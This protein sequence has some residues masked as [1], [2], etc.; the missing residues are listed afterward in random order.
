MGQGK[1]INRTK[2]QV[3]IFVT[4]AFVVLGLFVGL[5]V[6]AGRGYLVRARLSKMVDAAAL[7]GAR[8]LSNFAKAVDRACDSAKVNGFPDCGQGNNNQVKVSQITKVSST[9]SDPPCVKVEATQLMDTSFIRLGALIGCTSCKNLTIAAAGMAAPPT[10]LDSVVVPDATVS[11]AGAPIDNAKAG[12]IALVNTLIP[13]SSSSAAKIS[14]VPFRGC[15]D[16]PDPCVPTSQIVPLSNDRDD[17]IN[18]IGQ[19]T[20]PAGA[21]S[22]TNICLGIRRG[23]QMLFGAGARPNAK[24]VLIILTDGDNHYSTGSGTPECLLNSSSD[25]VINALDT[26]TNNLATDFKRG[27]NVCC[28]QNDGQTVEF[29]VIR[30]VEPP[31]DDLLSGN[32]PGTCDRNLVGQGTG[33]NG[34]SNDQWDKNLSRCIASNNAMGDPDP[35]SVAPNDHYYYASTPQ[36]IQQAFAAIAKRLMR[37]LTA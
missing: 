33:R 21:G 2:G 15:F 20:T 6:D 28:G 24:K 11:M 19:I 17:L 3:L 26:L 1:I 4:L 13:S 29:F 37:R 36:Q 30:Y 7:A 12:A 18:R 16:A 27:L 32:P 22:G 31:G 23:R 10:L 34:D 14:L 35:F 5:A 25:T 9:C 8:D